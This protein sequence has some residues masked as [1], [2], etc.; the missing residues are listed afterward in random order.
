MKI[1]EIGF[2]L[3]CNLSNEW[4]DDRIFADI[5]TE[6]ARSVQQKKA[7]DKVNCNVK[8]YSKSYMD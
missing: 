5:R 4:G 7:N 3:T 6:E 8:N 1:L 2:T